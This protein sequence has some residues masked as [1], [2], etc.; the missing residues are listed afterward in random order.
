MLYFTCCQLFTVSNWQA[1]AC[2][3]V[4][5]DV[6]LDKAPASV[7]VY[8]LAHVRPACMRS[9]VRFPVSTRPMQPPN[10]PSVRL[11]SVYWYR[12]SGGVMIIVQ[13]WAGLRRRLFEKLF[14]YVTMCSLW[15]VYSPIV[16]LVCTLQSCEVS[17]KWLQWQYCDHCQWRIQDL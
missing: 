5:L 10:E 17:S 2:L 14:A 8:M 9:E 1:V 4:W 15:P 7:A 13:P 11:S 6:Q 12:A 16:R 3:D